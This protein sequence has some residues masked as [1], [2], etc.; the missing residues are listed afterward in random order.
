MEKSSTLKELATALATFQGKIS[1]VRKDGVNPF[2]KSKYATLENIVDTVR[3]PLKSVGLSFSQFPSGDNG[4]V[5]ILMHSSGEFLQ[6]MV[7]M[8]PKDNTPQ[9]QGSAITYMRRYALASILGIVTEEDDDGNAASEPKKKPSA[10]KPGAPV[11]WPKEKPKV[12]NKAKISHLMKLLGIDYILAPEEVTKLTKLEFVEDNY[13]EIVSRLEVI[14]KE[15]NEAK[16]N[17]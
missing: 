15:R 17:V 8:N 9:G 10:I 1:S 4:L 3:E 7:Q 14:V 6:S 2:F 16:K 12:S 5:T 11:P 13:P